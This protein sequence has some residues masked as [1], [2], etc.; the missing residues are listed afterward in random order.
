MLTCR[1]CHGSD[2]MVVMPLE[3]F[4]ASRWLFVVDR[5]LVSVCGRWTSQVLWSVSVCG[6]PTS[7]VLRSVSVCC[8][9][10]SQSGRPLSGF[11]RPGTQSARPGTMEQ[12]LRTPRTA[13]TARP[14]TATSGRFVRLGTVSCLSILTVSSDYLPFQH[15][16]AEQLKRDEMRVK[17]YCTFWAAVACKDVPEEL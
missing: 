1:K 12:A 9:P 10:T 11:A 7:Q 6:R 5:R 13:H 14:V 3:Q 16:C 4:G 2:A 15:S 8:R 17:V